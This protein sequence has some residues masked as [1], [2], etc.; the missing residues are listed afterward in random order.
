MPEVHGPILG[1]ATSAFVVVAARF[2]PGSP[3]DRERTRLR[4]EIAAVG[5]D[6]A[7]TDAH[8]A[9]AVDGEE[10]AVHVERRARERELERRRL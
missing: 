4:L 7:G 9:C 5:I 10:L 1:R 8:A 3:D 6:E 2:E